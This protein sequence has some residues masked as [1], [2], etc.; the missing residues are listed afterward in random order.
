MVFLVFSGFP[1]GFATVSSQVA[2]TLLDSPTWPMARDATAS[3]DSVDQT[4]VFIIYHTAADKDV[5]CTT[6]HI[7]VGF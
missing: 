7:I 6:L 5:P 3:A 1:N 4:R 2:R